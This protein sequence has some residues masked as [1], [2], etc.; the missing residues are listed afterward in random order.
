[1]N[2]QYI[3]LLGYY[4]SFYHERKIGTLKKNLK[5]GFKNDPEAHHKITTYMR[6]FD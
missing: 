6:H 4:T 2:Y 1:M 3:I 5:V